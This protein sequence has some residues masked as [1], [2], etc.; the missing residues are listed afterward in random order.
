MISPALDTVCVSRPREPGCGTIRRKL[1]LA[2]DHIREGQQAFDAERHLASAALKDRLA[3]VA[4][5]Y[6]RVDASGSKAPRAI[7]YRYASRGWSTA[8]AG[9]INSSAQ[10]IGS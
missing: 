7:T 1:K 4:V 10:A 6:S 5:T 8:R 2:D 3:C 9:S